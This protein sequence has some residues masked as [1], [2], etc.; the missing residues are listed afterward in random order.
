MTDLTKVIHELVGLFDNYRG[1]RAIRRRRHRLQRG[2]GRS[3]TPLDGWPPLATGNH[4]R[5]STADAAF[6]R[7]W[8]A[9]LE[10]LLRR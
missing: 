5:G 2:C 9:S 3:P 6:E 10:P 8:G 4:L 1:G 7:S